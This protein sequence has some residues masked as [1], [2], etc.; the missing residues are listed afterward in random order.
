MVRTVLKSLVN[1]KFPVEIPLPGAL[2]AVVA[3]EADSGGEPTRTNKNALP[4]YETLVASVRQLVA[5]CSAAWCVGRWVESVVGVYR[6]SIVHRLRRQLVATCSAAWCVGRWVES[7]V[8]VYRP[9]IVHRLRRQLVA[10]CSAA[11]CVG[12][13]VE[14]VVGVYRPSIVH[15]LRRRAGAPQC[16]RAAFGSCAAATALDGCTTPPGRESERERSE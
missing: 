16:P 9:S 8:G 13:W 6:P 15:R 5:T 1:V 7:V 3:A 2:E 4:P 12:R 11:W 14:S 10:T